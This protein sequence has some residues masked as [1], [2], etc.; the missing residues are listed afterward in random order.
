[1]IEEWKAKIFE[2]YKEWLFK[3]GG[4]TVFI[5]WDA[6]TNSAIRSPYLSLP[7]SAIRPP[8]LSLPSNYTD[9]YKIKETKGKY[10]MTKDEQDRLKK[11]ETE[12]KRFQEWINCL[13]VGENS[14]A[15]R[16]AE[17][18]IFENESGIFKYARDNHDKFIK[19]Q[20]DHL[21]CSTRMKNIITEYIEDKLT[22]AREEKPKTI[23]DSSP[24]ASSHVISLDESFLEKKIN[25][26][27]NSH[28]KEI[29]EEYLYDLMNIIRKINNSISYSND[30]EFK[31][32][33]IW[34]LTLILNNISYK[35]EENEK[36]EQ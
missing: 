36:N 20:L 6:I 27:V 5:P 1:M 2:N 26:I 8:Y 10:K 25:D 19:K 35:R 32:K 17:K 21:Q 34:S 18:Y 12:K 11:E 24:P 4:K 3:K 22:I 31:E 7:A 29:R 28:I 9:F 15:L 23:V 33:M 30:E 13:I 16:D 14:Y